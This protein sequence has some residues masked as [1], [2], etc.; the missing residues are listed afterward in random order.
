MLQNK[1]SSAHYRAPRFQNHAARVAVD[2]SATAR[3]A[4]NWHTTAI[5]EPTI[6]IRTARDLS[7][8]HLLREIDGARIPLA[9]KKLRGI[10]LDTRETI[11]LRLL[12]ELLGLL[13]EHPTGLSGDEEWALREAERLVKSE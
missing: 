6:R 3:D 5:D 2:I 10:R 4:L 1:H 11:E 13:V 8:D 12:D 9:E 7:Y